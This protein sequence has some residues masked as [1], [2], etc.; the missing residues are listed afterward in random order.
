MANMIKWEWFETVYDVATGTYQMSTDYSSNSLSLDSSSYAGFSDCSITPL[1]GKQG[2]L[3]PERS[4]S[5]DKIPQIDGS[6]LRQINVEARKIDLPFLFKAPDYVTLVNFTRY[7]TRIL[8]SAKERGRLSFSISG[9]DR[10]LNCVYAGGMSGDD[11]DDG[12]FVVWSKMILSFIAHDP[13]YYD[14]E[15]TSFTRQLENNGVAFIASTPAQF[16]PFTTTTLSPSS[17]DEDVVIYNDEGIDIYP[18]WTINGPVTGNFTV[19]NNSTGKFFTIIPDVGDTVATGEVVTVDTRPGFKI[20]ESNPLG[21]IFH[22]L[23]TGSSLFPL[24][25]GVN[26]ITITAAGLDVTSSVSYKYNA[27]YLTY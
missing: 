4:F 3:A 10:V 7:I 23:L 5:E 11:G 18:I 15:E 13:Y 9:N 8:M 20:V 17:I 2:Y 25:R 27:P 12:Q 19:M 1:F 16:L 14:K 24:V 6:I 26:N 22:R 21:D